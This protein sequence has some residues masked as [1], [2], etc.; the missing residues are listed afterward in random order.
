MLP[1]PIQRISEE[2]K[3]EKKEEEKKE[4]TPQ[5]ATSQLIQAFLRPLEKQL[6]LPSPQFDC[7]AYD[8]CLGVA[9]KNRTHSVVYILKPMEEMVVLCLFRRIGFFVVLSWVRIQHIRDEQLTL[10]QLMADPELSPLFSRLIIATYIQSLVW[11]KERPDGGLIGWQARSQEMTD[12]TQIL[13]S[14]PR[15]ASILNA[16]RQH[17]L[18]TVRLPNLPP[19]RYLKRLWGAQGCLGDTSHW[20]GRATLKHF[21]PGLSVGVKPPPHEL[22]DEFPI[23]E[24]V[25]V[26]LSLNTNTVQDTVFTAWLMCLNTITQLIA[27][28]ELTRI[29]P[30]EL[31]TIHSIQEQLTRWLD[32]RTGR[33]SQTA[34]LPTPSYSLLNRP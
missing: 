18:Q 34:F 29:S 11:M 12:I 6:N 21:L 26:S 28:S 31:K 17:R 14:I 2:K 16:P 4:Y 10:L 23:V 19:W 9:E 8:K 22:K 13:E 7:E 30:R 24:S 27:R 5:S 25:C 3:E 20:D 32:S 33:G 1:R 15:P